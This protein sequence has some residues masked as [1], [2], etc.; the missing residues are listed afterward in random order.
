[1]ILKQTPMARGGA[2]RLRGSAG[3]IVG[4]RGD[5]FASQGECT[6]DDAYH[7]LPKK[8]RRYVLGRMCEWVRG[9][10]E[11]LNCVMGVAGGLGG[12]EFPRREC[13]GRSRF[14]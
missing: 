8:E 14:V 12:R 7:G 1:M 5:L 2:R 9:G 13:M 6:S 3:R 4:K 10:T 11:S